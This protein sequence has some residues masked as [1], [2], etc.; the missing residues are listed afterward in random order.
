MS[1][2]SHISCSNTW[3]KSDGISPDYIYFLKGF[4]WKNGGYVSFLLN[5]Q[6][7]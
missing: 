7:R 5:M 4:A 3:E 6:E 2:R 1:V